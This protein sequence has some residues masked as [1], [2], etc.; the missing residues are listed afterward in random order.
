MKSFEL[1]ISYKDWFYIIIVGM[2]F[3]FLISLVFY[4]V[5]EEIRYLSTI[6]F[7]TLCA[8]FISFFSFLFISIS[9]FYILPNIE[10]RYWY[11]ISFIFSFL[12]GWSG[13]SLTYFLFDNSFPIIKLLSNYWLSISITIGLL[14]FLIGLLL[15]QFISMKYKNE[16]AHSEILQTK[17]EVLE[18]ELNPHFLFNALNSI[19]ELIYQD[20][21]KAEESVLKLSKF[22]RNAITKKGLID[23]K[24]EIDMLN[25]YLHIE[26]IR[27]AEKIVFKLNCDKKYYDILL[28]KFSIQLLVENAI[29]HGFTG[30]PLYIDVNVDEKKIEVINS[31]KITSN[32]V[33]G[34]GLNNLQKRLQILKIGY[35]ESSIED[36]R[37]KF[38]IYRS[39]I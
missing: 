9:N 2:L 5:N 14:T 30:E 34:V 39:N 24:S 8:F 7:S 25:N 20:Q 18:S 12:A 33:F 38:T 1:E 16:L 11:I 36:N 27:F 35:L 28:P 31:G 26:N 21:K 10:K 17:L 3:G 23:L 37:M 15:H 29:K 6:I 32:I 13:F 19:S 22:L 4:Y